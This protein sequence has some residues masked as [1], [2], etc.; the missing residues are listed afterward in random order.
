MNILRVILC[1]FKLFL[2]F[3]FIRKY[4]WDVMTA[5]W[6][7]MALIKVSGAS[8]CCCCLG[9]ELIDLVIYHR[10]TICDGLYSR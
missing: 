9:F 2:V 8:L 10:R 4:V 5:G 7:S 6:L 3:M 1:L